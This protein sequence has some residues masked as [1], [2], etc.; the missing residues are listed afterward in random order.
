MTCPLC[1]GKSKVYDSIS[2][3]DAI[4]R[5]RKCLECNHVWFTDECESEGKI[6]REYAST[7]RNKYKHKRGS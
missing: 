2:D 3:C 6:Y 5:K 4:Y 7:R 1:G